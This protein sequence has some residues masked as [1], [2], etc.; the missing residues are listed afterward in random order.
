[1]H[2]QNKQS[3]DNIDFVQDLT[4]EAAANYSGGAVDWY[5]DP[6]ESDII[7]YENS[8]RGGNYRS[9]SA[10]VGDGIPYLQYVAFNDETSSI[11]IRNGTYAFYD[12]GD[13][14]KELFTLTAAFLP[15]NTARVREL[16]SS[17]DKITSVKR[18]A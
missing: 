13:Y 9:I 1:M 4:P 2:K 10:T 8:P 7:L 17:N 14:E 16:T 3:L 15:P 6:N 18:I 12:D 11:L 5:A